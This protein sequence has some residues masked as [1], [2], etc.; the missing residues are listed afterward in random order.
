MNILQ[1]VEERTKGAKPLYEE[2]ATE[3]MFGVSGKLGKIIN[4]ARKAHMV[5]KIYESYI[6]NQLPEHCGSIIFG[7]LVKQPMRKQVAKF[8][9]INI[10]SYRIKS[11]NNTNAGRTKF[12]NKVKPQ[13][14]TMTIIFHEADKAGRHVDIHIGSISIVKRLPQDFNVTKNSDGS[15]TQATKDRII[16]LVRYEFNNNAWLAQ[17]LDHSE[18]DSKFTWVG[19]NNGPTNYGSGESRQI[20]SSE[21]IYVHPGKSSMEIIAPHIINNKKLYLYKIMDKNDNRNV[22]IISLGVKKPKAPAVKDRLH[23]THDRD[24]EKFKRIVG[25]DS[26]IRVKYDGA[27]TYIESTP[28]GTRLWSPRISKKTGERIEYTAKVPGI[29]KVKTPKKMV[30]MGELLF[31]KNG[32]YLKAHEIGGI[33]NS[34][35]LNSSIKPEIRVYRSD[36]INNKSVGDVDQETN[37]NLLKNLISNG[38]G[39]IKEPEKVSFNNI[40]RTKNSEGVVGVSKDD[41]INNGRKFKWKNDEMDWEVTDI[42]LKHGENGGVAGVVNFKSLESGKPFKIG[43]SSMGN[44][45]SVLDIMK[46]PNSYIGKVAKVNCFSGHEGRA[47]QFDSWH[48]DK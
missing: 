19:H 11:A 17:N 40:D 22:P 42:D 12:F 29:E 45:E 36:K 38:Q 21:T 13:F 35:K 6:H 25:K 31:R 1:R 28:K 47:A 41:S 18:K 9:R 39:I 27:S 44:R 33:L 48:L 8:I 3:F 34:S 7:K 37:F 43:A 4:R 2:I 23:L 30:S 20:V 10:G 15:I 14:T 26:D 16:D 46:N 32:K 24:I 5:Y